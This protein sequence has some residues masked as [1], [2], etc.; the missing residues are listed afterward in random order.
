MKKGWLAEINHHKMILAEVVWEK[1]KDLRII[2]NKIEQIHIPNGDQQDI[3]EKL[4]EL[5]KRE[6][7]TTKTLKSAWF[8]PG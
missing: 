3:A 8:V 1:K 5:V 2:M 7:L 6:K 4:R